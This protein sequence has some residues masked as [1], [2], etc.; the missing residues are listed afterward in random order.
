ML[1]LSVTGRV[2]LPHSAQEPLSSGLLSDMAPAG[3]LFLA[4]IILNHHMSQDFS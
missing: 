2:Q 1:E 4:Y 3:P